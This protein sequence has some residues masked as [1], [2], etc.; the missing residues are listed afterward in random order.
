MQQVFF[1]GADGDEVVVQVGENKREVAKQL[2]HAFVK[3][4]GIN[5]YS[6]NP[7]GVIMGVFS[8]SSAAMGI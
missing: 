1:Q 7:K 8:M 5:K 3:P 4:N 6:N 2:V